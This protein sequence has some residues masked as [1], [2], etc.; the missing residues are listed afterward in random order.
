[1]IYKKKLIPK[2]FKFADIFIGH[3]CWTCKRFWRIEGEE[4][5]IL[6]NMYFFSF[7]AINLHNLHLLFTVKLL[8]IKSYKK[9]ILFSLKKKKSLHVFQDGG[10][11]SSIIV[12]GFLHVYIN[13]KTFRNIDLIASQIKAL[14]FIF[15]YS[16]Q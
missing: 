4:F 13:I 1:M 14:G 8:V 11:S 3:S 5:A 15:L 9:W 16:G 12:Q 6:K 7:N 10:D 2:V